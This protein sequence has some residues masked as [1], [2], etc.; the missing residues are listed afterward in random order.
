ML[1]DF[2]IA[3]LILSRGEDDLKNWAFMAV[4]TW[5]QFLKLIRPINPASESPITK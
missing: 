5:K 2:E 1:I 4:R 3:S